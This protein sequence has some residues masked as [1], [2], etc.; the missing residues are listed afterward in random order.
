MCWNLVCVHSA[1]RIV[2]PRAVN[3]PATAQSVCVCVL[4]L[5]LVCTTPSGQGLPE[6][7]VGPSAGPYTGCSWAP[8]FRSAGLRVAQRPGWMLF[9]LLTVK[10]TLHT[11]QLCGFGPTHRVTSP[12]PQGN[13]EPFPGAAPLSSAPD[14]GYPVCSL[15]D[16]NSAFTRTS[17]EWKQV[18]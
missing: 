4:F 1:F 12:P 15:C 14:S 6:W 5:S 10:F 9:N 7:Q 13:T 8:V 16:D 17:C 2:L 18:V 11:V 3:L